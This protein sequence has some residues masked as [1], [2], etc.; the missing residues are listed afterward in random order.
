MYRYWFNRLQIFT[1]YTSASPQIFFSI[2]IPARNEGSKIGACLAA[3]AKQEYPAH[4]MEVIVVDDH[5][6]DDTAQV[7]S[8][9]QSVWPGLRLIYLKDYLQGHT[10][11]AYKKKAIEVAIKEA[12]GNWIVT[13]DADCTMGSSW[14]KLLD[15]YIQQYKPVL[16]AAPVMFDKKRGLLANFQLLDFVSL[17]GITAAA[18]AAGYHSMC[19]GANLAYAKQAF[20]D[21]DQFAGIDQIASG[22]DMLLMH[23]MKQ[24]F[25]GK[26]GFLFHRAAIVYTAPVSSWHAFFQQRI[27]WASKADS[28]A[29]KTV[30]YVLLMVYLF[31]ALILVT[32]IAGL[33][34]EW[35]CTQTILL[36]LF[37]TAIELSFMIPVANFFSVQQR[38]WVFPFLQPLHIIYTVIAGWLG[39]FGSYKWKQREVN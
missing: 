31:N 23:K 9:Y 24:K 38:L 10:I 17:Q 27:R 13:T 34:N 7:V 30:F 6:E 11:N 36:L 22:D 8:E 21:V 20:Y 37:K 28:Y 35:L 39:K 3:I 2:I 5:S 4:L 1:P 26:M 12:K 18:V 16:V 14:L 25:P 33:W 19:N 32:F 29:D 15:A